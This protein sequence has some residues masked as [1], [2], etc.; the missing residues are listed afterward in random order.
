M[1]NKLNSIIY[2]MKK[3]I[4]PFLLLFFAYSLNAQKYITRNGYIEFYGKTPLEQIKAGNNQ[5]VSIIDISTGEIVFLVLMKSF[6]FER[7]L[8][9]EHFNENYVE[10]EKYPKAQFKGKITDLSAIDFSKPGVYNVQ[11]EGTLSLHN[12]TNNISQPGTIE[13]TKDGF[14]AKSGFKIKPEDYDMQIP[15]VVRDKIAKEMDVTVKMK[16]DPMTQ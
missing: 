15:S 6:R 9:E 10:S 5:V 11:V 4:F 1:E 12:V 7:A 16:Y 3:I 8:M 14:L 13:V 2:T